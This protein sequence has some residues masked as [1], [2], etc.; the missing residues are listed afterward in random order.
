MRL[1]IDFKI[2]NMRGIMQYYKSTHTQ[3]ILLYVI[4]YINVYNFNIIIFHYHSKG[5]I[6]NLFERSLL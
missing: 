5:R 4:Q 3:M 6:L 1:T 2:G